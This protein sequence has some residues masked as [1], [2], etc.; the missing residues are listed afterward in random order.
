MPGVLQQIG[1]EMLRTETAVE[2]G[3]VIGP[4]GEIVSGSDL[5]AFYVSGPFFMAEDA[6][7]YR[8]ESEG[9]IVFAWLVPISAHEA[10]YIRVAGAAAFED[11]MISSHADFADFQRSSII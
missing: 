6:A 8:N 11:L 2:P 3:Q 1:A 5:V 4:G 10:N 7:V 9:A